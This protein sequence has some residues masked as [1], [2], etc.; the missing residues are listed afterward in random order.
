MVPIRR[1]LIGMLLTEAPVN[2]ADP[3][4]ND[5]TSRLLQVDLTTSSSSAP[6]ATPLSDVT[7]SPSSA[8]VTKDE[9]CR[10]TEGWTFGGSILYGCDD[11]F[12]WCSDPGASENCCKCR[13]SC[14][15][16]CQSQGS[17]QDIHRPCEYIPTMR[18]TWEVPTDP[19]DSPVMKPKEDEN[20]G[21]SLGAI[22]GIT[23]GVIF[24]LVIVL[25]NRPKNQQREVESI[26]RTMAERR[27]LGSTEH[28]QEFSSRLEKI[29]SSFFFETVL[30]D[31]SNANALSIRSLHD[32][33]LIDEES[34]NSTLNE[35]ECE[36]HCEAVEQECRNNCEA[37]DQIGE[38]EKKKTGQTLEPDTH[39]TT[40]HNA[41]KN[42]PLQQES[43]AKRHSRTKLRASGTPTRSLR[44]AFAT[45]TKPS[46]KDEC[47]ICLEG[48]S[49]GECICLAKTEECEHS[50]TSEVIG[51]RSCC[52]CFFSIQDPGTQGAAATASSISKIRGVRR[53]VLKEFVGLPASWLPDQHYPE[54]RLM[55][56]ARNSGFVQTKDDNVIPEARSSGFVQTKDG[57]DSVVSQKLQRLPENQGWN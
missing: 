56:E 25:V 48:Y 2:R 17:P 33:P 44:D 13:A 11:D 10:N 8:N 31:K 40:D 19:L 41:K 39:D 34:D 27:R 3:Q 28:S 47:C 38:M 24:F 51:T 54:P 21:M 52:H 36:D 45:W 12:V 9:E 37:D 57:M 5:Y 6:S 50:R 35:Q 18:P 15:G 23:T 26:R 16:L 43:H 49:P 42:T 20:D 4:T 55:P 30:A 14:C 53:L 32:I 7:E 46:P 1:L 29:R 22:I